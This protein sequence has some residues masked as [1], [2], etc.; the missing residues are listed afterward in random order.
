MLIGPRPTGPLYN[1]RGPNFCYPYP[2]WFLSAAPK[3]GSCGGMNRW[4][5]ALP[6]RERFGLIYAREPVRHRRAD[7][8][9]TTRALL[10]LPLQHLGQRL[11]M[12]VPPIL[13]R[14]LTDGEVR[15][16]LA[17]TWSAEGYTQDL[18]L[19]AT[20]ARTL[21]VDAYLARSRL[22]HRLGQGTLCSTALRPPP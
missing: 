8:I 13:V 10:P 11:D 4:R 14:K 3:G 20:G 9:H 7:T 18:H 15:L 2:S 12:E 21:R 22:R 19:C 1:G 17:G 16:L 5:L 6:E